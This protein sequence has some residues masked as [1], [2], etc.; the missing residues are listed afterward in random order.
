MMYLRTHLAS[1]SPFVIVLDAT[2][3]DSNH[4]NLP[5]HFLVLHCNNL[6]NYNLPK[7]ILAVQPKGTKDIARSHHVITVQ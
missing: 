4:K 2:N 7:T 1:R 5:P 3:H 6:P